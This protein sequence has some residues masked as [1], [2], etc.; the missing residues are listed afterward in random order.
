MKKKI[1]TKI[2]KKLKTATAVSSTFIILFVLCN[3]IIGGPLY[4]LDTVGNKTK[5]VDAGKQS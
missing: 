2:D 4:V 5:Y 3:F 1:Q